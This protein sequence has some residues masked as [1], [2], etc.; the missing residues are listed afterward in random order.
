MTLGDRFGQ[1]TSEPALSIEV[2]AHGQV[3]VGGG[4]FHQN[5]TRA[6]TDWAPVWMGIPRILTSPTVWR[7][8]PSIMRIVVVLPASLRPKN[9]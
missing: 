7:I 3:W 2:F 1:D 4:P 8:R 9:P 5:S 6:K